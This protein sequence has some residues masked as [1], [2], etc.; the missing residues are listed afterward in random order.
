MHR[1]MLIETIVAYCFFKI[2]F[3]RYIVYTIIF[4]ILK[5]CETTSLIQKQLNAK[6]KCNKTL[7]VDF[8]GL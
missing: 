7:I 4:Q 5:I 6:S 2:Y 8:C 3:T 1:K